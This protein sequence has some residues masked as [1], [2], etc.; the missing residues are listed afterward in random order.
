MKGFTLIELLI[1]FGIMGALA[2]GSITVFSSYN[3]S[4]VFGAAVSDFSSFLNTARSRSISQVKPAVCTDTNPL[5]GYKVAVTISG[6][7]YSLYSVCLGIADSLISTKRLP[8]QVMFQSGQPNILFNVST[9]TVSSP[10]A[11]VLSGFGS[12]VIATVTIDSNGNISSTSGIIA[13]TTPTPTINVSCSKDYF[14]SPP[15]CVPVGGNNGD[16]CDSSCGGQ[17]TSSTPT[18]GLPTSTPSPTT[19]PPTATPTPTPT[20]GPPITNLAMTSI[21]PSSASK[22]INTTITFT[23]SITGTNCTPS[24][25]GSV[26]F[27]RQ[28]Y[29]VRLTVGTPSNGVASAVYPSG[30]FPTANTTYQIYAT[31]TPP[32]G[33]ICPS[34]I[35]NNLPLAI[36]N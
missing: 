21:N 36:S 27:F 3:K 17:V 10:G 7:A 29:S 32:A 24:G 33:N 28:G 25:S 18:T 23:A 13:A 26:Q 19:G 1:V 2:I 15:Y 35:S 30:A 8:G 22:S 14:Y 5:V 12:D 9:G 6:Q 31:Y 4:Q 11:I 34:S 16:Y 20:L